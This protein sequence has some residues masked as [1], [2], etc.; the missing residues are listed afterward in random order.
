MKDLSLELKICK[1][2]NIETVHDFNGHQEVKFKEKFYM[3]D[4]FTCLNCKNTYVVKEDYEV[5]R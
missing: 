2:C 5:S 4:Y 3:L 1:H